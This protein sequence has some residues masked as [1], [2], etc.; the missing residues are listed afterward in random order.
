MRVS[1]ANRQTVSAIRPDTSHLY[2]FIREPPPISAE[3]YHSMPLLNMCETVRCHE[4]LSR[5]T[6]IR[7]PHPTGVS[8]HYPAGGRGV[9]EERNSGR[10]LPRQ[11][12]AHQCECL[13]QR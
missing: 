3:G 9:E 2:E 1:T 13:H 7:N 4:V 10:A 11:S 8:E 5:R 6:H 12:H